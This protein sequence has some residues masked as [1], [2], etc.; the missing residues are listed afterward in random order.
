MRWRCAV[1]CAWL[2][3]GCSSLFGL[4]P[5]VER[6][7]ASLTDGPDTID[8]AA[9]ASGDSGIDAAQQVEHARL[10]TVPTGRVTNGP[11]T[12]FPLLLSTQQPWLRTAA[13]GGDVA[14][15][16]GYDI[17]FSS[18]AAGTSRLAHEVESWNASTGALV[19]WIRIPSLANGTTFYIHYGNPAITTNQSTP[20]M[21]WPNYGLVMHMTD[22]GDATQQ[23]NMSSSGLVAATGP[24]VDAKTFN[25]T[26]SYVNASSG[27]QIDDVFVGG[28][29]L[30]AWIRP[31]SFGESNLGR[32]LDKSDP[33][34]WTWYVDNVNAPST[35]SF[36]QTTS[37]ANDGW[38]GVNSSLTLNAWQHV[39][40]TYDRTN[41]P[42]I[43][44]NGAPITMVNSSAKSGSTDSDGAASLF[45]GNNNVG[46]RAF[47]GD[48]DE[49]RVSTSS[50]SASWIATEYTNQS[51]PA[52][53]VTIGPAL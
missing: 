4:T 47:A 23:N 51:T 39:A 53:F 15:A 19:A 27:S 45:V 36:V 31:S 29:T 28:G 24:V 44:V 50:R 35:I 49:V 18:D 48:I 20:T 25:G 1:V 46:D 3:A 6:D 38:R 8:A 32:I 26:T 14:N 42:Q 13:Q 7:D 34:G 21:V 17:Y 52:T 5:P 41:M 37:G 9:D 12:D 16:N 43:F 22:A 40:V 11:H 10:I 33:A 2:G 30:E